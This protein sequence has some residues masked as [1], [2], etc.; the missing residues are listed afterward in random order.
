MEKKYN[1]CYDVLTII[2]CLMVVFFHMN[3]IVYTFSDTV[4][5]K[6]S[7]IERCIVYSA[8]PIFFMLSG[9]KLMEY[10]NRYS[11]KQ[12]IQ[13]RLLRVGIPFLFWNLFYIVYQR[14]LTPELSF[15][16]VKEFVSMFLNSQF[17][18]RYWFFY[19]LFA[20]YAAIPVISLVL[21]VKDHRKYL[22]FAV[23][24]TFILNWVL[25]PLCGLLGVQ[26]N[27]HLMMPVCG[28]YMMYAVFGYLISTEQ[29]GRTKRIVLYLL[30]LISG[31]FA[32]C[33]TV[34]ASEAAGKTVQSLF[35]YNY[36]PSALTGAAIFVFVKHL[37]D[38]PVKIGT[39]R[40][41][42]AIRIVS[43]CCMGVWLSHSMAITLVSYFTHLPSSNYIYRFLLPPVVF[44]ACV[45]GTYVVKKIPILKHIV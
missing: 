4:S 31:I 30:A 17:Q 41:A 24:L 15:H 13:K 5:W 8:I 39:G 40:P 21:Q 10:R 1:V 3:G 44:A 34:N 12:Y 14:V 11:T 16:S 27:S 18:E 42:K 33:Y 37:F 6:I 7:V 22:W 9:A 2:A 25:K 23:Y 28:G 36:F 29:W 19:P 38:K 20:V 26:F 45:A 32:I 35:S 43:S